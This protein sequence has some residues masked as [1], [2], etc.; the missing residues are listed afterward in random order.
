MNL[1]SP[2]CQIRHESK[3]LPPLSVTHGRRW[4]YCLHRSGIYWHRISPSS[5][6]M[7]QVHLSFCCYRCTYCG[8][9]HHTECILTSWHHLNNRRCSTRYIRLLPQTLRYYRG[10]QYLGIRE[11]KSQLFRSSDL[12]VVTLSAD[13]RPR[14]YSVSSDAFGPSGG[15]NSFPADSLV[16]F[17]SSRH[18][19]SK[20]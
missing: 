11:S 16:H 10:R 6:R 5:R 8:W 12:G 9:N 2:R 14:H 19:R 3:R 1:N 18:S 4:R 13:R 15:R 20:I 7:C 17:L